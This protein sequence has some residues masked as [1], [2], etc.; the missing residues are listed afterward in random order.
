MPLEAQEQEKRKER[1][2][3]LILFLVL[4]LLLVALVILGWIFF[5]MLPAGW[6]FKEKPKPI[7]EIVVPRLEGIS[8]EE[9]ARRRAGPLGPSGRKRKY[10]LRIPLIQPPPGQPFATN[11]TRTSRGGAIEGL[12]W[13]VFFEE[14]CRDYGGRFD[15]HAPGAGF[16][17]LLQPQQ[18]CLRLQRAEIEVK[19]GERLIY[20]PR[21]REHNACDLGREITVC[22]KMVGPAVGHSGWKRWT[23]GSTTNE[24]DPERRLIIWHSSHPLDAS[25]QTSEA[26]PSE[27]G[28]FDVEVRRQEIVGTRNY[29]VGNEPSLWFVDLPAVARM[30]CRD[31]Y[32]GIDLVCYAAGDRVDYVFV[33]WP[34]GNP[35]DITFTFDTADPIEVDL[36]GNLIIHVECGKIIQRPP[37]VYQVINGSP[38]PLRGSYVLEDRLVHFQMEDIVTE[39][40]DRGPGLE[41]LSYLGGEGHE[42]AYA[43][44]VDNAGFAYVAGE[45]TSPA[46]PTNNAAG[47]RESGTDVFV[48]KYRLSDMAPIYTTYLGGQNDDR[49]F[50]I[51]VDSAGNAYVCGET[52]SPDFPL[53]NAPPALGSGGTFWDAFAAKLDPHGH[54]VASTRFGGDGDDRCYAVA[55]GR[56]NELFLAGETSSRSFPATQAI[57]SRDGGGRVDAF[58]AKLDQNLRELFYL[59]TIG[60]TEENSAFALAVDSRGYAC[61]AGETSSSNFP[62]ARG[63]LPQYRGGLLDGFMGKLNPTGNR[64]IY[65]SFWGGTSDDRVLAIAVDTADNVYLTGETASSDFPTLNPIQ[66]KH[67]G[68]KWDAFVVKLTGDRL[69]PIYSTFLGGTAEDRGFGVCPDAAG[70]AHVA[71]A[72]FSTNFPPVSPLQDPQS[73]HQLDGF[74]VK[75]TPEGNV[76]YST[77]LGGS[78]NDHFFSVAVDGSRTAHF[79]GQTSSATNLAVVRPLQAEYGGGEADAWIAAVRPEF[80]PPPELRLVSAGGQP[81]GL[82]YDFYMSRYEITNEEFVRF[83]NDAQANTN[84]DR[85]TNLFFDVH[86]NVWINPAMQPER[87]E[88]F[89][90]A[91]SRIVYNPHLPVG[92]R[93]S[94]SPQVPRM[95]GSYSNHPVVGVSWYGAVKF[96]N[97]L[98]LD[99]G[100]GPDQRCYREGTNGLDWAPVT[101]AP[102]NWARGIFTAEE[103]AEWLKYRGFRLPMDNCAGAKSMTNAY[104]RVSNADF[105]RFLNSVQM[106]RDNPKGANTFFDDEGNMWLNPAMRPGL[107]E[108]FS[109]RDSHIVYYPGN[110]VGRRY[111]LTRARPP[112]GGSY[113]NYPAGGISLFGAMKFCNWLTLEHGYTLD[114]R[115]YREGTNAI[116]WAPVTCSETNWIACRFSDLDREKLAQ[117]KGYALPLDLCPL[118]RDWPD[119]QVSGFPGTNSWPN[120]FNEFYK[121]AAWNGRSN[122]NFGFG[123]DTCTP[124]DA[125]SLDDP[126]AA[127]HDTTPVGFYDGSSHDGRFQTN[128]NQ[129]RYGIF[130]LSANVEEWLTDP[131]QMYSSLDRACYGRSW[132]FPLARNHERSYVHPHFTDRFRGFRVVTTALER[133][134]YMVRLAYRICLCGR[135]YGPGCAVKEEKVEKPEEV[136]PRVVE[137]KR[138]EVERREEIT[139]GGVLYK[140]EVYKPEVIEKK[141]EVPGEVKIPEESPSG[142]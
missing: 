96:C 117:L 98:T 113:S 114:D 34:G 10:G 88:A 36:H 107:D 51:A 23:G 80:R 123:M 28:Q 95:G 142:L 59:T 108:M 74:S 136:V 101:C 25:A 49:A 35:E 112:D 131:G 13:P 138:L 84:N 55:L 120:P 116:D 26:A 111:Q 141:R 106:N 45:V 128:T 64:L 4:L 77:R 14:E 105:I 15:I 103:R 1:R 90:L 3:Y 68:G 130:D 115:R 72:T 56:S 38:T 24:W 73:A 78:D 139:P 70:N 11:V 87:D 41:Y 17:L 102:T 132:L 121:A 8:P 30:R 97:W 46:Q 92:A 53:T 37:I 7:P 54:I 52:L 140:P 91:D 33:V 122:V 71:G 29:Y 62:T 39:A 22:M 5:H 65:S 27:T 12:G 47:R 129:N 48:C 137:K 89:D 31:I 124:R 40:H 57:C 21:G 20:M 58:V 44:A 79:C 100:R 134:M 60:G 133:D 19:E 94:V 81:N 66:R 32:P 125:N 50:A 2:I 42:C 9:A 93:Y 69:L 85:G 67:A 126:L 82:Q 110:P 135:G 86:G 99:T 127:W 83:L 109:I 16:D 63:F 118:P 119:A 43:I 104:L 6:F 18:I 76:V 61:V 75:I